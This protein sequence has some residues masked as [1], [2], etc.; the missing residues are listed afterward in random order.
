MIELL[1]FLKT[2]L[3]AWGLA[4]N[5][6][7]LILKPFRINCKVYFDIL[8]QIFYT[9]IKEDKKNLKQ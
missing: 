1:S 6:S 2:S 4:N 8:K 9:Q 5:H 3:K 7:E